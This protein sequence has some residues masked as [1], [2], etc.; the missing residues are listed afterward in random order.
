MLVF[1]DESGDAGFKIDSSSHLIVTMTVFE[2]YQAADVTRCIIA[3]LLTRT[4]V[5]REF[6]FSKL[7][8]HYKTLFFETVQSQDF[9]VYGIAMDKKR[10]T[11]DTLHNNTHSFFNFTLRQLMMRTPIN[12]ARIRIDGKGSK[13]M[14]QEAKAYFRKEVPQDVI[15]DVKYIDSHTEPLIQLADMVT[16][17][18]AREY[19]RPDTKDSQRYRALLSKRIKN[20]WEFS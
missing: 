7:A 3:N 15:K 13:Q 8:A 5:K 1:I 19:M 18:I 16:G 10:I 17:A 12:N 14:R 9:S 6:H 20:V 2:N 4:G 11:S